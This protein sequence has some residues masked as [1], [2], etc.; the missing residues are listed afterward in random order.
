MRLH[1]TFIAAAGAQLLLSTSC[2]K[3]QTAV[4]ELPAVRPVVVRLA[5][6]CAPG[7]ALRYSGVVEPYRQ[8]QLAFRVGGYVQ[9]I[10][11]RRG[12][13]GRMRSLEPGDMVNKGERLASLRPADYRARVEQMAGMFAESQAGEAQARAQLSQSEA[14]LAQAAED[15]RR[16]QVLWQAKALIKPD[17]DAAKA[18]HESLAAQVSANR[19]AISLQRARQAQASADRTAARV[20]LS[21]TELA[22]PFPAT[23]LARSVELGTLAEAGTAAFALADIRLVKIVFGVPDV[24]LSFIHAGS[25]LPVTA[26]AFPGVRFSGLVSSISPIADDQSRTYKIQLT[27]ENAALRLKPGMV[28]DIALDDPHRA[29]MSSSLMLPLTALVRAGEREGAFGVY[30]ISRSPGRPTIYRQPVELTSV[31]GNQAVIAGGLEV[32]DEVVE[33]GGSLL[34]DGQAVTVVR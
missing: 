16:A 27:I 12:S 24:D 1:F 7:E 28:T 18:R 9:S 33:S 25:R 3:A 22:A 34:F 23:V 30:K 29:A 15:W 26:D 21:D 31:R 2:Q 17:F 32:G 10:R 11:Q 5:A 20:S 6:D 8:V 13:D 4:A 19:A 14:Q